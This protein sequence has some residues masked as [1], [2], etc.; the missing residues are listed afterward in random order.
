M[1]KFTIEELDNLAYC[2]DY[3]IEDSDYCQSDQFEADEET[4][5]WTEERRPVYAALLDKILDAK[6]ATQEN[7]P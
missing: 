2:V 4:R 6:Q 3:F 5:E 1:K 7:K